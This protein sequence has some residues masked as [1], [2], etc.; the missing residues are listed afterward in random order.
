MSVMLIGLEVPQANA[1][2]QAKA[3]KHS[4]KQY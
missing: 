2:T 1:D 4:E 3:T